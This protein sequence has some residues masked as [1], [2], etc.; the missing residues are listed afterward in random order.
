M[1]REAVR[2]IDFP[3]NE[4]R[5]RDWNMKH[6]TAIN[7]GVVNFPINETRSRDWN[8]VIVNV[9][10]NGAGFPINETR[11]RDWNSSFVH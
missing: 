7:P 11:S 8:N 3:I 2:L 6:G 10:P 1:R 9:H 4:T 5:S